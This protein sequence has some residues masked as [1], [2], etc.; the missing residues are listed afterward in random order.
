MDNVQ[1]VDYCTLYLQ[2]SIEPN[3]KIKGAQSNCAATYNVELRQLSLFHGTLSHV[4]SV[5]YS[6]KDS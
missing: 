6:A 1:K 3:Y 5:K 2:S 4:L